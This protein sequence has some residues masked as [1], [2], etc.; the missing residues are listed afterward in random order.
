MAPIMGLNAFERVSKSHTGY[1]DNHS[2]LQ[3]QR[4]PIGLSQLGGQAQELVSEPIPVG[5][6]SH[7]PFFR[8][9]LEGVAAL[10]QVEG[11]LGT[12]TGV[13]THSRQLLMLSSAQRTPQ[14]R[15]LL[16]GQNPIRYSI[17]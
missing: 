17:S 11:I 15:Q 7:L 1:A 9:P 14:I 13:S 10:P 2:P 12:R 8:V 16:L 5:R 6:A 4:Y 3:H